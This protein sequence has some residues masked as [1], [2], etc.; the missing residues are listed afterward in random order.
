ME[1]IKYLNDLGVPTRSQIAAGQHMSQNLPT[2]EKAKEILKALTG[3][4]V[5][6]RGQHPLYVPFVAAYAVQLTVRSALAEEAVK[7]VDLLNEAKARAD[8]FTKPDGKLAWTLAG[9]ED[10]KAEIENAE[11]EAVKAGK[12]KKGA[13][14]V[15]GLRIY[16][17]KIAGKELTRKEAIAILMEEVGLSAAGASTYYANFKSGKWS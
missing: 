4:S 8:E 5:S 15:L 13:R 11:P 14:K 3:H 17:E 1:A 16:N 2:L 7:A 10:G 9:Y 12:A 6:E